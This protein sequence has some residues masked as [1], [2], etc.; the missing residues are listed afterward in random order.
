MERERLRERER[1]TK[2]PL[3]ISKLMDQ[4]G[5]NNQPWVLRRISKEWVGEPE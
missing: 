4:R 5:E 2:T 1:D 3:D